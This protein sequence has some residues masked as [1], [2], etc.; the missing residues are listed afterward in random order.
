MAIFDKIKAGF[1]G[2]AN[3]GD[4]PVRVSAAVDNK[5]QEIGSIPDDAVVA[6]DAQRGVQT[7][8]A[9]TLAWSKG[10]LIAAF[11]LYV[12]LSCSNRYI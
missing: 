8:E 1:S 2:R 4:E 6:E 5:D 3:E 10:S 11:I 12:P 9:T 7:V